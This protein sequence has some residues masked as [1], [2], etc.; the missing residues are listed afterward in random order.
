MLYIFSLNCLLS[1]KRYVSSFLIIFLSLL[2]MW[3]LHIHNLI[4]I[5]G[6]NQLICFTS[7]DQHF[8]SRVIKK[9]KQEKCKGAKGLKVIGILR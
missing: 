1:T 7:L 4:D 5:N 3:L 6:T 2:N 9:K 8:V